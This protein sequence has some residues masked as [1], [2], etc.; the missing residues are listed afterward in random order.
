MFF[1]GNEGGWLKNDGGGSD[2]GGGGCGGGKKLLNV[3]ERGGGGIKLLNGYGED[4]KSLSLFELKLRLSFLSAFNL[5]CKIPSIP[6]V[7]LF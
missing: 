1:V 6:A 2:E 4:D 5:L 3:G 7:V